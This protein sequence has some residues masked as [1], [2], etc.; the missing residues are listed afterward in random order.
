MT[1]VRRIG[2]ISLANM[3]A[4]ITFVLTLFVVIFILLVVLP[5]R[6]EVVTRYFDVPRGG[7]IAFFLLVP[8]IYAAIGWIGGALSALVY[9]LVAGFTGG[10]QVQLEHREQPVAPPAAWTPLA[11]PSSSPPSPPDTGFTPPA[12]P[13]S[14]SSPRED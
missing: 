13:P 4:A 2:V 8:F 11:P 5:M 9:N 3:F 14:S 6:D 1:R 12:D 10:V 7:A